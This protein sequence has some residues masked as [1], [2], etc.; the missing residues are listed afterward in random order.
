MSDWWNMPE[1]QE[2][3]EA[4]QENNRAKKELLKRKLFVF[5]QDGTIYLDYE[6]LPGAQALIQKLADLGRHTIFISNNSSASAETYSA[7]LTEIL[8]I[9]IELKNIYTSS[10][11]TI[12]YL[13]KKG[14]TKVY[15]LGT[16][17]FEEELKNAGISLSK[18]DPEL[19]VLAFD[20]TLNYEKLETACLLIQNGTKYIATHPD[21]VCPTKEGYIPDAGSF[22]ALIEIATGILPYQVIGKPNPEIINTLLARHNLT[23]NDAIIFGDRLYTDIKL[24]TESGIA[25]ALVLTGESKVEDIEK[26]D[27]IPD[28][29]F[30]NMNEV[31]VLL[32]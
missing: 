13:K 32:E 29:V 15:P 2:Q 3:D 4:R 1:G 8:G 5:D 24:G 30:E 19:I 16:P 21:K 23:P 22:I 27:V 11:A 12:D 14:I 25:T 10:L 7:R 26:F 28:L 17:E 31:L 9:P 6:P 20:K 18:E